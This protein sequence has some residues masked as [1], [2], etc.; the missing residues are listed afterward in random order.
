M[1]I[2]TKKGDKG[3]THLLGGRRVPRYHLR[4]ET[5]GTL[6]ELNAFLGLARAVSENKKVKEILLTIQNHFYILGSDLSLPGKNRNL[7]KRVITQKEVE[8][9][10]QL[11]TDFE[12]TLKP[13]PKF[14]VYGETF[15]SSVLDV[16]RAISRR[17]ERL[18]AKMKSKK[19]LHNLK[20]L[21]YLNRL[22]DVLYLLAR[23]EEKRAKVK[24][25]QSSSLAPN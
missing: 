22:S 20:I 19:M 15:P 14:I 2:S 10:S 8:W 12:A 25:R 11:S 21:E 24:P 23:Y 4:P 13:D 6:D 1:P 18:V 9:L 7:L 5:Y 16:A 17:T 3:F